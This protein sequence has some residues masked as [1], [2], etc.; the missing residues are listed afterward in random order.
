MSFKHFEKKSLQK[1]QAQLFSSNH[2]DLRSEWIQEVLF[3]N[4]SKRK[5]SWNGDTIGIKMI[6]LYGTTKEWST[7]KWCETY[8]EA[9]RVS[10]FNFDF[11]HEKMLHRV[12]WHLILRYVQI[13]S[14]SLP[15][16]VAAV[17][18]PQN[19]K[20]EHW[21]L[22][23]LSCGHILWVSTLFSRMYVYFCSR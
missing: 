1:V 9:A 23:W 2:L 19:S 16:P 11:K 12:L 21:I 13:L 8:W 22:W 14:V 17:I 18:Q 20:T 5:A 7:E 15:K 10:I 3:E 6:V 4:Q